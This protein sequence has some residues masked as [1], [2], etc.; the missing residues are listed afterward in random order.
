MMHPKMSEHELY[1]SQQNLLDLQEKYEPDVLSNLTIELPGDICHI[2]EHIS[3]IHSVS[4]SAI[5]QTILKLY[6]ADIDQ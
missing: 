5:I 3:Y 6:I 1:T 2:I 4:K